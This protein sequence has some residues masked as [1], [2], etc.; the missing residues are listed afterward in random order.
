MRR[1]A[2]FAP[3]LA[4]VLLAGCGQASSTTSSSPPAAAAS[5]SSSSSAT[6][7]SLTETEFKISPASP[8][9]AHTGT[10]TVTVKNSGKFTHALAVKTPSGVV[11]TGDIAPG[12]TATLTVDVAKDGS[13]VF[14]CPL[15]N[16]RQLGMQGTLAVGTAAAA[17][18]STTAA[19]S[20]SSSSKSGGGYAY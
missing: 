3:V 8:R 15:H 2:V 18:T 20:S 13:Y 10:I 14:Y 4:A 19:S 1:V 16:H 5:A 11:R 12:A 17:P 6:P 7:V 9:I